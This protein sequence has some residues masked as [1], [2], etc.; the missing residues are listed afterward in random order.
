MIRNIQEKDIPTI[1]SWY[2][3]YIKNGTET[4]ETETIS[5]DAFQQRVQRIIKDYPFFV[6]EKDGKLCGYVYLDHFNTRA[7]YDWTAD[8]SLYLDPTQRGKGYGS[9]LMDKILQVAKADGYHNIV[10]IITESNQDSLRFHEKYGFEK[11]ALLKN[12]GY[13]FDQWLGVWYCM[14]QLQ[15]GKGVPRTLQNIN[16]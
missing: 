12:V 10:S 4:F 16:G 11:I 7:A 8:L 1:L 5:L 3:W 6:L 9:L 15:E 2:N 14:K 13:K